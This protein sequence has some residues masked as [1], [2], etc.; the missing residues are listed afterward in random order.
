MSEPVAAFVNL[1]L[2]TAVLWLVFRARR[3]IWST[4]LRAAWCW[5]V[6]TLIVL[7]AVETLLG[8][9]T[10]HSHA[11]AQNLRFAAALLVFTPTMALL[12]AKRPQNAAWQFV[13]VTLWGVLTLPAFELWMRG[14]GEELV[15]DPIRSWFL[16]VMIIVGV[17]NHLP[18]R[19]GLAVA[20][21]AAAQAVLVWSHLPFVGSSEIHLPLW[22]ACGLFLTSAL[23]ARHAAGRAPRDSHSGLNVPVMRSWSFVWREFRDWFGTVW[24]V[25]VMERINATAIMNHSPLRLGW[26]GFHWS[27]ST[28][29][30]EGEP[31]TPQIAA[32]QQTAIEQSLRN[33]LRRFVTSEWVEARLNLSS[34][35]LNQGQAPSQTCS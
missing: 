18:T 35:S 6:L 33:L 25:R 22:L 26:D 17:V 14:R 24:G 27:D 15:I 19:F 23:T 28:E 2:C 11:N 5:A 3:A 30:Q 12:G 7:A 20:Q 13:V 4:T 9:L 31:M 1:A 10:G 29:I 21:A 32:E 16:V 8:L 34:S